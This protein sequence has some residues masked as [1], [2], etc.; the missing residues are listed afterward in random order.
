MKNDF[1]TRLFSE[2]E[3]GVFDKKTLNHN[4]TKPF[5]VHVVYII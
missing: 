2:A 4:Y 3:L 1:E 5:F